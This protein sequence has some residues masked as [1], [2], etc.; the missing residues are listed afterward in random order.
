VL[1]VFGCG[2]DRDEGKRPQMGAIAARAADR[3][4]ITNDNPRSED[5]ER[6]ADQIEAGVQNAPPGRMTRMLDRRAAIAAALAEARPGEIVLIAGKGHE[7]T[8]TIGDR[9]LPFD[10]RQ[11]ARELLRGGGSR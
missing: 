1:L 3:A 7:T 9:V 8:Q 6:I 5:P 4:W 2:G 11:V 10:D